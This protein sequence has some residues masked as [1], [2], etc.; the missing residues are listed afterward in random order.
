MATIEEIKAALAQA[1]EEASH[2]I[3]GIRGVTENI[4]RA[5][6]RLR[7]TAAGSGAP[8]IMQSIAQL[9]ASK[10]RLAEAAQLASAGI[11]TAREYAAIL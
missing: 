10:A 3:T 9:E 8:R 4:D 5:I 2:G 11:N 6:A 1:G 7:A